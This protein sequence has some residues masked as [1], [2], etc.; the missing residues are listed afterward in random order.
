VKRLNP[1]RQPQVGR[2]RVGHVCFQF[3]FFCAQMKF[4][5]FNKFFYESDPQIRMLLCHL[6]P[7]TENITKICRARAEE[8]TLRYCGN[9]FLLIVLCIC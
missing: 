5:I 9:T 1:L 4:F 6:Q 7:H 2:R 3:K 8:V